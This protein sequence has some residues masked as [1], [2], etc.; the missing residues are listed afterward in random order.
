MKVKINIIST[1]CILMS[2]AVTMP[3]SMMMTLIVS[4]ESRAKGTHTNTHTHA[5]TH[6]HT[7]F[8]LVYLKPFSK[9]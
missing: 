7:H 4:D 9:S 2:E 6:T 1:R 3:S 8:C 5:H